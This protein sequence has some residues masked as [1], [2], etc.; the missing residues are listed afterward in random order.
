M[1]SEFGSLVEGFDDRITV[2]RKVPP[3]RRFPSTRTLYDRI[4]M[5]VHFVTTVL[6]S[7]LRFNYYSP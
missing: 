3:V 6:E 2:P 4:S 1:T 7:T 5:I